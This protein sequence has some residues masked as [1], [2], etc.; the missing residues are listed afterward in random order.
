MPCV[1]FERATGL[2]RGQT[3]SIKDAK[4]LRELPSTLP[5]FPRV[6]IV[7]FWHFVWNLSNY[8]VPRKPSCVHKWQLV[9]TNSA[10]LLCIFL[11]QQMILD[12]NCKLLQY[13]RFILLLTVEMKTIACILFSVF[14]DTDHRVRL[15]MTT[16]WALLNT[17]AVHNVI[18][19]YTLSISWSKCRNI[20]SG[21]ASF[22]GLGV[23]I[24][25]TTFGRKGHCHSSISV[26]LY[27]LKA[28]VHLKRV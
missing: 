13:S 17:K 15:A 6:N 10:L 5:S 8:R 23:D 11:Y 22:K 28:D 25:H 9:G 16:V 1:N 20:P 26:Y 21:R 12:R 24:T 27:S 4:L 2:K 7:V 18:V 14:L 19:G 3:V